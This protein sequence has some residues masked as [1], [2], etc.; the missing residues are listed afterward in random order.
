MMSSAFF[1]NAKKLLDGGFSVIPCNRDKKPCIPWKEF[2]TR[3]ATEAELKKWSEIRDVQLGIVTGKISGVTILDCDSEAGIAAAAEFLDDDPETPTVKTPKGL[4]YY[5]DYVP[6]IQN[7]VKAG[8]TD[9]DIRNDGGYVVAPPSVNCSG[10]YHWMRGIHLNRLKMP[11]MMVDVFRQSTFSQQKSTK[12]TFPPASENPSFRIYNMYEKMGREGE[13]DVDPENGD[14]SGAETGSNTRNYSENDN[15]GHGGQSTFSQHSSTFSQQSST[16]VNKVNISFKEG[17][18][19]NTIF[20]LAMHL[21]KSG[22]PVDEI[23][24]YLSFIAAHCSPAYPEKEIKAKIKS[25]ASRL[26]AKEGNSTSDL[27]DWINQTSGMFSISDVYKVMPMAGTPEGRR[28][29]SAL[30]SRFAKSGLIER[31]TGKN[32][33]FR[34]VENQCE[35]I[36][37]FAA[38]AEPVKLWMPLRLH[39][40]VNLMPGNMAVIAGEP[41]AGKTAVLMA[42]AKANARQ[43]RI[44]YFSSEMGPVE[45][46]T[47]IDKDV[48]TPKDVWKLINFRE[49]SGNFADVIQPGEG[50]VNVIDFLEITENFYEI[51]G[52]LREIHD[53]LKGAIAV[54]AIQKN[55][56]QETG[57]G[58]FRGLEKPRLYVS[59]SRKN[60]ARIVKAK[61]WATDRN[62]N[63]L[64]LNYKIVDG[65][66]IIPQCD[67]R[68][69]VTQ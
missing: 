37:P 54:I 10:G 5:F 18:R 13:D 58:G 24:K 15:T 9:C 28:H 21:V 47:R 7:S 48:E 65:C 4:H 50:N 25:A 3:Y 32:G 22:M 17:G 43:F 27:R 51:S 19:D 39:E 41:D 29:I 34:L 42:M 11:T 67:W 57:L 45:L 62:P 16:G 53:K 8:L 49:R 46:R 23:E 36:D 60:V 66:K 52:R 68:R 63:G 55:A 6:D 2:Q 14:F 35:S 40:L 56:G 20:H 59:M 69:E 30:L 1:E 64:I 61:N 38:S 44:H 26:S 31:I 12:S 33:M